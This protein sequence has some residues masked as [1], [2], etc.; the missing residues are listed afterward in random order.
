MKRFFLPKMLHILR[1]GE[2]GLG[3][4]NFGPYQAPTKK[5][6]IVVNQR[7]KADEIVRRSGFVK[8]ETEPPSR[9]GKRDK[10]ENSDKGTLRISYP[11]LLKGSE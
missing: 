2:D 11:Q 10:A 9:E 8:K 4:R 1:G 6:K 3:S 5:K 7:R